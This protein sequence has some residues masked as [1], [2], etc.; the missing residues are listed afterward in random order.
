MLVRK[1]LQWLRFVAAAAVGGH[2]VVLL[3]DVAKN[4]GTLQK[5]CPQFQGRDRKTIT[6][7][8]CLNGFRVVEDLLPAQSGESSDSIIFYH[9]SFQPSTTDF[10]PFRATDRLLRVVYQQRQQIDALSDLRTLY[11]EGVL[12]ITAPDGT[13]DYMTDGLHNG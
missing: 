13:H 1:Q 5:M 6:R 12:D 8:M 4:W 10:T 11:Q 7:W 9:A 3:R 2:S